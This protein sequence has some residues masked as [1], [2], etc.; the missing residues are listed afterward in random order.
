MD[1]VAGMRRATPVS[2]ALSLL[3]I[4]PTWAAPHASAAPLVREDDPT[5]APV[6]TSEANTRI[7]SV[8]RDRTTSPELGSRFA[9][10]V[11]D[12]ASG[13][14]VF[15]RKRRW[16]LRGAS[17]TKILTAVG[18]LHALGPDHRFPTT[19][20][21]G[22]T[23]DEVVLVGGGDP[24]LRSKDLRRLAA[25]TARALGL[26]SDGT[27]PVSTTDVEREIVVRADDSLFRGA[28][29]PSGWLS[30]YLPDEVRPVDAF[31]RDDRQVWDATRDAGAFFARALRKRGVAASYGGSA[32]AAVGAETLATFRGHSL[33]DAVSRMLLVS[34]NDTAE[35]LFRHVALARDR[36]ATWRGARRGLTEVLGEL[37]IPLDGVR[38]IDG[39]GLSLDGRVTATALTVALRRAL[40]PRYPTLGSLRGWLPVAGQTGTLQAAYLRFHTAPSSCAAGLVQGKTGTLADA[41]SLAGYAAGADGRTKVYVALVNSRPTQ[42]SRLQTRWAVDRVVSSVTGCW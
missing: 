13:S 24:L 23:A 8:L 41:I 14:H 35:M 28:Q 40:S 11:W 2:V 6:A 25:R 37:R 5:S 31:A 30:T 18:I 19:V 4:A 34:D 22:T 32:R 3:L 7:R 15:S 21:A 16:S 39:S 42:Y 1:T 17:T 33:G 36:R 29:R 20:R 26:P 38:I 9:M 10:T 27:D 12:T